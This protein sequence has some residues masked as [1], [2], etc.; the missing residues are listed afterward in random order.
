MFFF[1]HDMALVSQLGSIICDNNIVPLSVLFV[2]V[3]I[4]PDLV[5]K[6]APNLLAA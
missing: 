2:V 3:G 1:Q 4:C 5:T 6:G